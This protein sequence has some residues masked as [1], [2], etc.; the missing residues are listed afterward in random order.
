MCNHPQKCLEGYHFL[1]P[2]YLSSRPPGSILDKTKLLCVIV[3]TC[4]NIEYGREGEGYSG[5]FFEHR[6]KTYETDQ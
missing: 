2:L 5:V 1:P 4:P 6:Y 3:V